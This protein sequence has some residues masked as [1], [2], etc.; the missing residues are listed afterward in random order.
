MTDIHCHI[1]PGVDDGAENLK[2]SLAMADLAID[3]GVRDIIAT[4]HFQGAEQELE[5]L[6]R[7]MKGLEQLNRALEQRGKPLRIHPGAEI[8]CFP[9]TVELAGQGKLPTLGGTGYALCEFFFDAPFEYMDRILADIA[10]A[11]YKIVAAHPE[12]YEAVIRDPGIARHWFRKGYVIQL[13]KG[14]VLGAFG[15][16]VQGTSR[17]LLDRGFVHMIAS[18][19]HS[20]RRRTTDLSHLRFWLLER[21]PEAYADLLLKE[22]PGRLLRDQPMVPTES[23]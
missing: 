23:H 13:D 18:D 22:N 17:W 10:G 4:P 11:G 3:C 5:K 8:L 12:R 21:Y 19:A 9:E 20:A 7:M 2:E 15:G 6:G 16:R 14:S 1:L